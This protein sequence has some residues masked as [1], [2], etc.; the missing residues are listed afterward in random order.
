[1]TI[2]QGRPFVKQKKVPVKVVTRNQLLAWTVPVTGSSGPDVQPL[3]PCLH[4]DLSG[5]LYSLLLKSPRSVPSILQA[6]NSNGT[7][8]VY[9]DG[10]GSNQKEA[11]HMVRAEKRA[12]A[13]EKLLKALNSICS[14]TDAT[15]IP[16]ATHNNINKMLG[17]CHRL[18][19]DLASMIPTGIA[20]VQAAGEADVRMYAIPEDD[21]IHCAISGDS[22]LHSTR[23]KV[24]AKPSIA[25]Y[26]STCSVSRPH[27]QRLKEGCR[28][29]CCCCRGRK[30]PT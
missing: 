26:T 6:L 21:R 22:D 25:S 4:L 18:P 13:L 9:L 23:M 16:K 8:T 20:R 12:E 11:T 2:K 19:D 10:P 5:S 15:R 30:D 14:L 27:N 1:M 29:I 3:V 17:Q 28:R 7:L 24:L